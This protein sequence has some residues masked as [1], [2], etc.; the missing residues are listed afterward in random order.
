MPEDAARP[1]DAAPE[2][3]ASADDPEHTESGAPTN[4]AHQA[5]GDGT[6]VGAVPAG[7]TPDEL[8]ALAK[9]D[10]LSESGTG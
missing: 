1:V 4:A 3:Q 2:P 8:L 5:V 7:L 10:Q 6:L 9:S